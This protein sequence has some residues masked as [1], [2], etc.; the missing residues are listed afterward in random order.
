[1]A[2]ADVV[3]EAREFMRSRVVLTAAEL[4][5]FTNL[6][7]EPKTASTLTEELHTDE[8]ATARLLDGL[9]ALDLLEKKNGL[10]QPT[11]RA[12]A[13][14]SRHPESVRPSL[15]HLSHLWTDWSRLT[16]TVR[17][18]ANV[19]RQAVTDPQEGR[20]EAFIQAMH[21]SARRLAA[22]IA[23]AYDFGRF[24][25]LL[26][27][28]GGPGT[29]AITFLGRNPALRVVLFDLPQVIALA[30]Q[31]LAA[32]HLTDRAELVPGDFYRDEL[33]RGCDGAWLSAIIHQN[34]AEQNLE[35]FRKVHRALEPGGRLL[36]RDHVMDDDRT[37]PAQGALFAIN[38][39]LVTEGGGTYT[40]AELERGLREA[41]FRATRLLRRGERMD[42]LVE[43]RRED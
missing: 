30:R 13:L 39:L 11:A 20:L 21:V 6:D 41:G 23:T 2:E 34:S 18:G 8:R 40:L 31:N 28:G 24:H 33:P 37:H 26:D 32:E 15:L 12:K 14:S 7:G 38:M 27:V 19:R 25:R 1:M 29:Y 5:V 10:Y 43:A 9:V 4:D 36:I 35:L 22:E 16:E 17:L 42:C 3:A